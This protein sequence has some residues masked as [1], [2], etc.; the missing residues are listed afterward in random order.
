MK[1]VHAFAVAVP[2]ALGLAVPA[3]AIAA[4]IPSAHG[5]KVSLQQAGD[6]G[7]RPQRSDTNCVLSGS[8]DCLHVQGNGQ[9]LS[10][11]SLSHWPDKNGGIRHG[12]LLYTDATTGRTAIFRSR[13]ESRQPPVSYG[14]IWNT[15]CHLPHPGLVKGN[16][17]GHSRIASVSIHS[18]TLNG[19]V[20]SRTSTV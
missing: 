10:K 1:R 16:V 6:H 18:G 20:C 4:A 13:S 9:F 14:F 19:N 15:F 7:T 11:V 8:H 17:S 2:A 3:T 5:K 12:T